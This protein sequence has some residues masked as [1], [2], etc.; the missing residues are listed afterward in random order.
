MDTV[1][2]P[3]P[4]CGRPLVPGRSVSEHHLIPKLKGGTN[5]EPVHRV[6]HDKIHATWDE[7][8]LRDEYNTWEKIRNAP[9]MESFIKW[10]RKKSAEFVSPSKMV[11]GHKR[12][13]RR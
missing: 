4:V 3:C 1:C 6:C 9:E 13:K 2:D 12:K 8:Q 11:R 5:K 7:N 10:V